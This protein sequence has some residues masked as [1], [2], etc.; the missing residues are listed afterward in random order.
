MHHLMSSF[1]TDED[2]F[3]TDKDMV[4][5]T[6]RQPISVLNS[7][8]QP[9]STLQISCV[10]PVCLAE[11]WSFLDAI[12]RW[13]SGRLYA[14]L[15]KNQCILE[16]E[17]PLDIPLDCT[18]ANREIEIA[19]QECCPSIFNSFV[20]LD[21]KTCR[22]YQ[23]SLDKKHHRLT[24]LDFLSIFLKDLRVATFLHLQNNVFL[25]FSTYLPWMDAWTF[26]AFYQTLE[27]CDLMIT[28]PGIPS[29]AFAIKLLPSND[30]NMWVTRTLMRLTRATP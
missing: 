12:N 26:G 3:A 10:I 11:G 30:T 5:H 16:A 21:V 1:D 24:L 22:L 7:S 28:S 19:I 17:Q 13:S 8:I 18:P 2:S 20:I 6:Q 29:F 27:I 25:P 15:P 14:V 23:Y 4:W 9:S